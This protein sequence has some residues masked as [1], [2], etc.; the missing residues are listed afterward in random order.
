MSDVWR[1][2][3]QE[4]SPRPVSPSVGQMVM[5]ASR[6]DAAGAGKLTSGD[7]YGSV[8]RNRAG[9]LVER[10]RGEAPGYMQQVA[11]GGELVPTS[12][13]A[14][15]PRALQFQNTV[16]NPDYVAVDA[17]RDRLELAHAAG[18]LEA[19]LDL[20]DSIQA[21]NSLEKMLAHQ[22]AAAHRA[23]M[24]MA[25]QVNRRLDHLEGQR[26]E[27]AAAQS[28]SVE[29]A[30]LAGATS[31]MMQ[32]FQQGMLTLQKL[33]TGGQQQVVVQH[34]YVTKVEDGGQ[35][36]IAP[37]VEPKGRGRGSAKPKGAGR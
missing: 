23:T 30:R 13:L 22:L 4:T 16:R 29:A 25:A 6:L 19:G 35:A 34:Q 9:V 17:S 15:N 1:D 31:R 36:V 7:P 37:K 14:E 21:E 5:A 8:E 26:I 33:R 20:A 18:A 27:G 24:K 12:Q 28:A 32:T 11:A 3:V 10:I 2:E